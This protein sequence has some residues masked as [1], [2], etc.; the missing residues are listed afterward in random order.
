M[1]TPRKTKL[2]WLD[3]VLLAA[4]A[5][6]VYLVGRR[7][8]NFEQPWRWTEVLHFVVRHGDDGWH[9][10]VLVRGLAVTL[11]IAVLSMVPATLIGV[12]MGL[13]R[14]ADRL[15]CRLV[16]AGYVETIR[17]LPPLVLLFI[18]YY[19]VVPSRALSDWFAPMRD[20]APGWLQVMLGPPTLW[21]STLAAV[22]GL[23][24]YEGAYITEIVRGA[25]QSV[26]RGQWEASRALG[27]SSWQ[28]VRHVIGPQALRNMLPPLSGQFISVVKDSSIVSILSVQ[29][30]TFRGRELA[31]S[32]PARGYTIYVVVAVMYL[33]VCLG[34]SLAVRALEA[35]LKLRGGES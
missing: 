3:A 12:V 9:A 19:F 32:E 16:G 24:V 11:R 7:L 27:L 20:S 29:E 1:T 8:V 28:A 25:V 4:V 30:L 5:G 34:L 35:R 22:V 2:S 31:A 15:F 10:G 26:P 6:G 17:N 33:V 21:I 13:S 14:T 23:A 18:V